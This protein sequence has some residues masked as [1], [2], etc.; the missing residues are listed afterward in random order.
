MLEQLYFVS[1]ITAAIFVVAS[2]LFLVVS[3]RQNS[4]LLQRSMTEDYRNMQNGLFDEI[5]RSR[6]FAEF[7]MKIGSEYGSFDEVDRYRAQFL[8]R[9]NLTNMMHCPSS[10]DYGQLIA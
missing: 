1:Q 8:A 5:T 9:K 10:N 2:I 6:E 7:H 3:V 4:N